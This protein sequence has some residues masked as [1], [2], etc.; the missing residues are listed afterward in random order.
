MRISAG[1]LLALLCLPPAMA[2][3]ASLK[4]DVGSE[5]FAKRVAVENTGSFEAKRAGCASQ[6]VASAH[7]KQ[8]YALHRASLYLY[9]PGHDW[10]MAEV[11]G[12]VTD[13]TEH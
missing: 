6:D 10:R 7:L 5:G 11:P 8:Q 3:A 13:G 9:N 12:A 2:D 1:C 4:T